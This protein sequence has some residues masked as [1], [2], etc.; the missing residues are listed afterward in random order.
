MGDILQ[1]IN[2]AVREVIAG[3]DAPAGPSMRMGHEFD[4][5]RNEIKHVVVLVLHI[6][7]H[8]AWHEHAET[9][10]VAWHSGLLDVF[11]QDI[12]QGLTKQ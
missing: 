8:P 10:A 1:D 11:L 9:L 6:L 3:V 7:L 2:Q 4:A 12:Q 5:V